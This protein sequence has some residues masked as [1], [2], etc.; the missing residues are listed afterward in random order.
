MQGSNLR[1]VALIFHLL[2]VF[3]DH[4]PKPPTGARFDRYQW[5]VW[6]RSRACRCLPNGRKIQY[7]VKLRMGW[8]VMQWA[9]SWLR[10]ET[11]LL[12]F[13]AAVWTQSLHASIGREGE[14]LYSFWKNSSAHKSFNIFNL[15]VLSEPQFELAAICF[16]GKSIYLPPTLACSRFYF[17][18][19][20]SLQIKAQNTQTACLLCR[21][22][23]AGWRPHQLVWDCSLCKILIACESLSLIHHVVCVTTTT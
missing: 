12:S 16:Y 9:L 5:T 4:R 18:I 15:V 10:A 21:S 13:E 14:Q 8:G 6:R 20:F 7:L 11:A 23:L 22:W 1:I 3:G 17:F 2:A 19:V